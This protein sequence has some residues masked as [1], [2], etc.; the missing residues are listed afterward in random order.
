MPARALV[1]LAA[2]SVL[3]AV[4]GAQ[5][6]SAGPRASGSALAVLVDLPG[7]EAVVAGEAAA[8]PAGSDNLGGFAYPGD[9]RAVVLA[10]AQTAA[11]TG[12]GSVPRAQASVTLRGVSL[13]GGEILIE[14]AALRADAY[15]G[16]DGATGAV[17]GS[18][19]GVV[20]LGEPLEPAANLRVPLGDWGYL[21]LLEQAEAR[22]SSGRRVLVSAAH[23][24]LT[25]AHGGL[26]AG[27]E[28]VV[29]YAEAAARPP[30]A[31]S[32]PDEPAEP[33][34]PGGAAPPVPR[35]PSPQPPGTR[36]EPPAIVRDPPAGVRPELTGRG[37]VFPVYGP[38]SFTDDFGAPRASTGWHHGND[39]F[40]RRGAPVLAVAG[41]TVFSVGWN[42]VG[43][44]RLW[45]RDGDGNEYY[46]AHLSAYT[47]LARDGARVAAGDV[48]GFAGDTGDALGTPPHLHFEVHPAGLLGLGYDGVVNPYPYLT[49]WQRDLD[50]SF[51]LEAPAPAAVLLEAKDIST[52]SGLAPRLLERALGVYGD[53]ALLPLAEPVPPDPVGLPPGL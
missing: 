9:G 30:A 53:G 46:Y 42:P 32:V 41:G 17:E 48:L 29:G 10:S 44:F 7:E 51:R 49:A 4:V 28:I 5:A 13:F 3:L 19:E 22:G 24:V 25:S 23:V 15:A 36:S 12:P 39:I 31:P 16:S 50:A 45:L 35:D 40:A 2:A 37:Y 34:E 20:V 8:P 38:V 43:G 52:S 21:V 11:R 27:T 33:A 6:A 26:P 47:P 1:L 14:A 18:L